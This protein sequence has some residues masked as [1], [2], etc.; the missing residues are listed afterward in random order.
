[1]IALFLSLEVIHGKIMGV[2]RKDNQDYVR[3]SSGHLE[4]LNGA[5]LTDIYK[6]RG[7]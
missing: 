6:L 7:L 4:A 3:Y 1:M 5:S 2:Y